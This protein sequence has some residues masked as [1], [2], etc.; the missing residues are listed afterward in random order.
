MSPFSGTYHMLQV[1]HTIMAACV[2]RR[3]AIVSISFGWHVSIGEWF[4]S[5]I[6]QDELSLHPIKEVRRTPADNGI[7]SAGGWL[8]VF[9]HT[10]QHYIGFCTQYNLH[11]GTKKPPLMCLLSVLGNKPNN[12][13]TYYTKGLI[14]FTPS[15][16]QQQVIGSENTRWDW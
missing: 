7:K 10:S 13:F 12:H 6:S 2:G 5:E 16:S 8:P 3:R 15:N 4:R 1:I 11:R 9:C 14:C